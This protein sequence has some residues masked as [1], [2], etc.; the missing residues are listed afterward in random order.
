MSQQDNGANGTGT[1]K[2]AL[3][4]F[5]K[6][7]QPL[8]KGQHGAKAL[9]RVGGFGFARG[10]HAVPLLL[11]EFS[12]AA[13]AYP[14]LFASDQEPLPLAATGIKP[15]QNLF[16]DEGD[17]W[18]GGCYVP[19]YV[20]RYPFVCGRMEGQ[21]DLVI[22][23]DMGSG[24]IVDEGT[25]AGA[26]PLFKDGEPSDLMS[27]IKNFCFAFEQQLITTRS[28]VAA[29][30]EQ[31]LLIQKDITFN[32]ASGESHKLTGLLVVDEDKFNALSDEIFL[33][34]RRRGFLAAVYAHFT[35][36]GN[37]EQIIRR[38]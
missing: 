19:A 14:I 9:H 36:L 20:R 23:A 30:R 16:L 5:F 3:P 34:W 38:G 8:H 31:E 6:D 4:L 27:Q 13:S 26:E 12:R 10:A 21:D 35:S 7:P 32:T 11:E 17:K 1:A 18:S 15:G 24:M 2:A 25:V 29:L 37:F 28:F 33:D 22:L